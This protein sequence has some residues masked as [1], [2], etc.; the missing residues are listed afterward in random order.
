MFLKYCLQ[1]FWRK[2]YRC[3]IERHN[4]ESRCSLLN[5]FFL[6]NR[7]LKRRRNE[8]DEDKSDPRIKD[9]N[10]DNTDQ[11]AGDP[12]TIETKNNTQS[13]LNATRQDQ[14]TTNVNK[15]NSLPNLDDMT[16]EERRR[17]ICLEEKVH[18]KV[19]PR[20]Q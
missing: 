4:E 18:T 7:I 13:S 6:I 14:S 5:R 15:A 20:K 17:R 2:Y 12:N 11:T 19:R 16:D 10:A 8:Q 3:F 9:R 1:Y